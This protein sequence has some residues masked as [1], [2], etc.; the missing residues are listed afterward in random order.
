MVLFQRSK[1]TKMLLMMLCSLY[2]LNYGILLRVQRSTEMK[3]FRVVLLLS[4]GMSYS[5]W[6]VDCVSIKTDLTSNRCTLSREK[7]D[8]S[9]YSELIITRPGFKYMY[10]HYLLFKYTYIPIF[11][12]LYFTKMNLNTMKCESNEIA[13]EP[14]S[15]KHTHNMVV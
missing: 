12:Y 4:C 5:L 15:A 3:H 1:V 11:N 8:T 9:P 2:L 13:F 7:W 10:F 14:R 6:Y